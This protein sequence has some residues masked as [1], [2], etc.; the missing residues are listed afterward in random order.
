M[1]AYL[2]MLK[3]PKPVQTAVRGCQKEDQELQACLNSAGWDTFG[4]VNKCFDIPLLWRVLQINKTL[5][6]VQEQQQHER[7]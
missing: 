5:C 6:E 3:G 7:R 1:P 4:G 2:R